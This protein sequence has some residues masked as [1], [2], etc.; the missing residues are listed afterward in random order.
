MTAKSKSM[1][2][3][4]WSAGAISFAVAG[5]AALWPIWVTRT[6]VCVLL[7]VI[8]GACLVA[9]GARR[10]SKAFSIAGGLAATAILAA[11]VSFAEYSDRFEQIKDGNRFEFIDRFR[12]ITR[13]RFYR[14]MKV[15]EAGAVLPFYVTQGPMRQFGEANGA[16]GRWSVT[17]YAAA[18][19]DP[20][21]FREVFYWKTQEVPK[22]EY[23]EK[24]ANQ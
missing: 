8:F 18:N 17:D 10:K 6:A 5:L 24:F 12:L 23:A 2:I 15:Y 1:Q 11:S 21:R 16:H 14:T 9:I 13:T 20:N 4:L 22:S 7:P 19:D 3:S